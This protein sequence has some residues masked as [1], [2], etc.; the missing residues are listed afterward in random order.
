MRGLKI[1][2][3]YSPHPTLSIKRGLNLMTLG[4]VSFLNVLS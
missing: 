3:L 4:V 1:L 2:E